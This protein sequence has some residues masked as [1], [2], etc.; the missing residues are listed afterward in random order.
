MIAPASTLAYQDGEVERLVNVLGASLL[1][2]NVTIRTVLDKRREGFD[3]IWFV[4]H[5]GPDGIV[6][7]DGVLSASTLVQSLRQAPPKLIVVNTCESIRMAVRLHESLRC[8]VVSTIVRIPD[9]SAFVTSVKLADALVSGLDVSAAYEAACPDSNIEY[10]L[11]NGVARM[12]GKGPSDD[13]NRLLLQLASQVGELQDAIKELRKKLHHTSGQITAFVFAWVLLFLPVF[14]FLR[15][16]SVEDITTEPA[17][18]WVALCWFA[19]S[20]L[21]A[22][23][24]GLLKG[25]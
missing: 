12:N 8:A 6:L 9:E 10:V 22:Y 13:T 15:I 17:L 24:F 20:L 1:I 2:D 14:T 18:A 11:L 23:Y 21:F 5:G 19:S 25:D 4:G 7:E 3:S 16:E